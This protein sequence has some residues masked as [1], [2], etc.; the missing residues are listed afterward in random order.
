MENELICQLIIWSVI[1]MVCIII[2]IITLGLTTIWFCGRSFGICDLCIL[3]YITDH[4]DIDLCSYFISSSVYYKACGFKTFQII[5]Y[6]KNK[7]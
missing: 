3:W 1:F 5:R 6:G 4:P 7:C 2:E